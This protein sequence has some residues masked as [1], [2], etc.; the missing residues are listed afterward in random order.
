MIDVHVQFN[1]VSEKS[2]KCKKF[3][4]D[5][6]RLSTTNN[7]RSIIVMLGSPGSGK[8]SQSELLADR[9]GDKWIS[10]GK[11]LRDSADIALQARLNTG[12]LIDDAY[13]IDVLVAA[14]N[15]VP[16][17]GVCILDGF[18]RSSEQAAWLVEW[19]RSGGWQIKAVVHLI[20]SRDVAIHRL[21]N[22]QRSDDTDAAVDVRLLE[23]NTVISPILTS[24]KEAGV[25]IIDI[26]ADG[27]IETI[28]KEIIEKLKD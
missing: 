6:D 23:Y 18:P 11:L 7:I 24:F 25:R 16:V 21:T 9:T 12:E 3:A 15:T 1:D 5:N 27:D 2:S 4:L 28:D 8:S 17:G 13:V 14:M 19:A 26:S 10:T 20:V 22:R